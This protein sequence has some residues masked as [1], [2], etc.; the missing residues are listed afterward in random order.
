[1]SCVR[2]ILRGLPNI[3]SLSLASNPQLDDHAILHLT[4]LCGTLQYLDVSD[5]PRLTNHSLFAV[6]KAFA[7]TL[8]HINVSR[9][10]GVTDEGISEIFENVENLHYVKMEGMGKLTDDAIRNMLETKVVFGFKN[11]T[12]ANK[13]KEFRIS[14]VSARRNEKIA[15]KLLRKKKCFDSHNSKI[16]PTHS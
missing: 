15:K 14:E 16:K 2:S 10:R 11:N 3:K 12:N 6:G 9:C 1:M 7:K 5:V 13:L 4:K 8:R